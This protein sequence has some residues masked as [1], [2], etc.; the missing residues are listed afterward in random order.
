LVGIVIVLGNCH[1]ASIEW[2][3]EVGDLR[4]FR[5]LV[6]YLE[7]DSQL[8]VPLVVSIHSADLLQRVDE[9]L[10]SLSFKLLILLVFGDHEVNVAELRRN[11]DFQ[12]TALGICEHL[13][14][15]SRSLDICLGT[16][17]II[18]GPVDKGQSSFSIEA[19]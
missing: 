8:L 5:R 7:E 13:D 18:N 2:K 6:E 4:I 9:V 14:R 17:K 19:R 12:L 15:V 16:D 3:Y 10:Y 11:G 1:R